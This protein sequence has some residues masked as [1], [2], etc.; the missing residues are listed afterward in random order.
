MHITKIMSA[1][2]VT[3]T[4]SS[5][6]IS[7][8]AKGKIADGSAFAIKAVNVG[9]EAA[10]R[11]GTFTFET[12]L[13]KSLNLFQTP[14]GVSNIKA[15]Y[16]FDGAANKTEEWSFSPPACELIKIKLTLSGALTNGV[17]VYLIIW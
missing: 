17:D 11:T 5:V 4:S 1:V 13:D 6:E 14:E 12:C 3:T 16:A 2:K 8:P 9:S 15:S 7:N 10:G